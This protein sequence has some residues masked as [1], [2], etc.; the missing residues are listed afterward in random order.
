MYANSVLGVWPYIFQ[1]NPKLRK[2]YNIYSKFMLSYFLFF[3]LTALIQLY[4]LITDDELKVEEIGANLSI[5][6]LYPIT[7]RRVLVIRSTKMKK[8][9]KKILAAEEAILG[10]KDEEVLKIYKFHAQQSQF[11]NLLFIVGI[12][13]QAVFYFTHPLSLDDV[14]KFNNVTNETTIIKALPMSSWLPYD[15]QKHYLISYLWHMFNGLIGASYV[16]VADAFSFSMIIFPLG[17]IRILLHVLTNFSEYVGKVME[18]NQCDRDQAS[19]L[20]LRECI[21]KH[22][23]IIRY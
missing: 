15:P 19:F 3:L 7:V 10:G 13:V 17:Q 23:E 9:I 4:I 14:V 11:T 5:T 8:L 12:A 21:I 18:Q 16:T 6:L 2:L 22:K 20:T 1:G